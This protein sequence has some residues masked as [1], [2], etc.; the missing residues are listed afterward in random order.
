MLLCFSCQCP[1]S[2]KNFHE[3]LYIVFFHFRTLM[4]IIANEVFEIVLISS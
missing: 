1:T 4:I 2:D 3:V